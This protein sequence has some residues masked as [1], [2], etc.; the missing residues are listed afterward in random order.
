M[1]GLNDILL[2]FLD[3][4]ITILFLPLQLVLVPVD[5]LLSNFKELAVIPQSIGAVVQFVGVWPSTICYLFGIN[6]VLFSLIFTTLLLFIAVV[7]LVNGLKRAWE[8]VRP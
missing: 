5:L 7:P 1:D 2:S 3:T 6:P 4:I 8:W